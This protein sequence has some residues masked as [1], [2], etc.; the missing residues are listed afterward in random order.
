MTLAT[1]LMVAPERFVPVQDRLRALLEQ[2]PAA[3]DP[4]PLPAAAAGEGPT[5][6]GSQELAGNCSPLS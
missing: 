5:A 2:P 4:A 1:A 6:D 3:A